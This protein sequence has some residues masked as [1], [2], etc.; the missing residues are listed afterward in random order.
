MSIDFDALHDHITTSAH[1]NEETVGSKWMVTSC[2]DGCLVASQDS[3]SWIFYGTPTKMADAA[4]CII[5]A[6]EA[7]GHANGIDTA[8]RC[9][10]FTKYS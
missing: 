2:P 7:H 5:D 1:R 9:I 4:I 3:D 10:G 6:A 8:L